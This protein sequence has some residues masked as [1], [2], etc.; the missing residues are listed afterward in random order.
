LCQVQN[1]ASILSGYFTKNV[2]ETSPDAVVTVSIARPLRP[3]LG[4]VVEILLS[5][6]ILNVAAWPG[7]KEILRKQSLFPKLVP[8]IVTLSP[9]LPSSGLTLSMLGAMPKQVWIWLSVFQVP[10]NSL[11][12]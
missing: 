10:P 11:V 9:A 1:E 2:F 7:P 12:H 8:V 5:L 4:T 6:S 3:P